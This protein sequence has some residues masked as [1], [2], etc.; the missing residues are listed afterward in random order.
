MH[1]RSRLLTGCDIQLP[2]ANGRP[3]ANLC[4][5]LYSLVM[6]RR[7]GR[8]G[9]NPAARLPEL[10]VS[11]GCSAAAFSGFW[12]WWFGEDITA[13]VIRENDI[14]DP[15]AVQVWMRRIHL[16][17]V[18]GVA[19]VLVFMVV[20]AA[21][22]QQGWRIMFIVVFLGFLGVGAWA[23]YTADW[24]AARLWSDTVGTKGRAVIAIGEGA[25]LPD[26]LGR[27]RLHLSIV[28]TALLI[29]GLTSF[30]HYRRR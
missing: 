22:R 2:A 4:V 27:V 21:I 6:A 23:G 5:G 29:V 14:T 12:L 18:V 26:E 20:R 9:T 24:E 11:I 25:R 13:R 30:M 10:F 3:L 16:A 17:C 1:Q 8:R 28:P 19:I 15:F 7:Y